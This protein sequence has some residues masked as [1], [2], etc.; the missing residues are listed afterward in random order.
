MLTVGP[1]RAYWRLPVR[2]GCLEKEDS[3]N[4]RAGVAH[5]E[6]GWRKSDS[7][8]KEQEGQLI[9]SASASLLREGDVCTHRVI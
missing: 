7:Q 4:L 9:R 5:T 1:F 2:E 8:G 6:N 3:W